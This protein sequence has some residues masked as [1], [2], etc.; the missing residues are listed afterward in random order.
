MALVSMKLGPAVFSVQ[1]LQQGGVAGVEQV[2]DRGGV[3]ILDEV[4]RE[5]VL[6]AGRLGRRGHA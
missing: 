6:G 2:A 3:P 1:Q 5:G 4:N